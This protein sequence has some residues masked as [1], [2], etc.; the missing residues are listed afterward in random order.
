M[1]NPRIPTAAQ[2]LAEQKARH[3]RPKPPAATPAPSAGTAVAPAKPT[4]VAAPDSR[5]AVTKYIDDVAPSSIAGRM[6]R[7][8]DG[9]FVYAD[10]EEAVDPETDFIALCDE[11]LAGWIRFH[12]DGETPPDRV[13]GLLFDGFVM[14]PR[15]S[16]GDDDPSK[17]DVGLNNQPEDPWKHQ[18]CLVLQAA[19]SRELATFVTTSV[20]G[21]RA[22]GNLLRHYERTRW[23]DGRT[24]PIVRLK[25]GG[26]NHRDE[27]VGWVP[28]PTFA[29][30]GKAPKDSDDTP[31]IDMNDSIPL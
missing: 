6:I 21:R 14:P 22:V 2:V 20:T 11:T 13:Q 3:A 25:V 12:K 1:S 24:Y 15:E 10:T 23:K 28:V 5:S 29:I 19:A 18:N 17:W 4:A 16:L 26:F 27:R 9:K 30:V 8:V 7:F 31:P